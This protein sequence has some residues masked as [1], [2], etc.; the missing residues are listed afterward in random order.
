LSYWSLLSYELLLSAFHQLAKSRLHTAA[1][2][3]R[4]RKHKEALKY[5]DQIMQMVDDGVLETGGA[6]SEKLTLVA[7]AYHNKA[8]DLLLSGHPQ[9]ACVAMQAVQRLQKLCAGSCGSFRDD[10]EWTQYSVL[11]A[12][13]TTAEVK[14]LMRGMPAGAVLQ[15][16]AEDLFSE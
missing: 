16:L 8:V 6:T 2:L 9:E 5:V 12:L 13:T 14:A 4:M 15:K 7:V 3:S 10:F 11:R 1:I